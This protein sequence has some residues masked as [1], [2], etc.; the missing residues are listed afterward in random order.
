MSKVTL[1]KEF[2]SQPRDK[3]KGLSPFQRDLIRGSVFD[4]T[5]KPDDSTRALG[6]CLFIFSTALVLCYLY[7]AG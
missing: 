3:D 4:A 5:P 1:T 2:Q 7:N 6:L